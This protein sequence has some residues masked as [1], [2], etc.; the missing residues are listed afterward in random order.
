MFIFIGF[1]INVNT[2]ITSMFFFL[3][4]GKLFH[5]IHD[6]GINKMRNKI[7]NFGVNM[8]P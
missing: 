4:N 8:K 1:I 3:G 6:N 2:G 7:I 5:F